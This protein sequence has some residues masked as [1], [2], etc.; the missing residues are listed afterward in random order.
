MNPSYLSRFKALTNEQVQSFFDNGYLVVKS[1]LDMA[2]VQRWVAE[3][4]DRLGYDP[5]DPRTWKEE[6]IWMKY[7][8]EM[9]IRTLAP[10]AW[11]AI[12][13]VVGGQDRLDPRSF[14]DAQAQYPF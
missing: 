9:P 4:F 2:V 1:C 13:D 3:G 8:N 11:E 6:I 7:K 12:L 5:N 10:R 14:M